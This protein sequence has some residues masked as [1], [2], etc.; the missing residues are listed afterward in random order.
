MMTEGGTKKACPQC[1][2][3]NP[4]VLMKC[5]N[6]DHQFHLGD[7]PD[8][9]RV[10]RA[11][12]RGTRSALLV[13]AAI[14]AL[15]IVASLVNSGN[16]N[17]TVTNASTDQPRTE[18]VPTTRDTVPTTAASTA[19]TTDPIVA[20]APSDLCSQQVT[21]DAQKF[22][23]AKNVDEFDS[24][25]VPSVGLCPG[26]RAWSTAV[27]NTGLPMQQS[28]ISELA[29]NA[30][31]KATPDGLGSRVCLEAEGIMKPS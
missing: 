19:T 29:K 11:K 9:Q 26:I 4:V 17:S 1:S 22:R 12:D 30:C 13:V 25:F 3:S 23:V 20:P 31:E 24:A 21:R 5:W 28:Q 7:R 16:G 10:K 15:L 14:V 27:R 18:A 6:C 2:A 8:V